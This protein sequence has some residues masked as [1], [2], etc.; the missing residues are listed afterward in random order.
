MNSPPGLA[1]PLGVLNLHR[2]PIPF[3][4]SKGSPSE[5][6]QTFFVSVC[7]SQWSAPGQLTGAPGP[8][9]R[10]V[11]SLWPLAGRC[12]VELSTGDFCFPP[13]LLSSWEGDT[14]CPP[15]IPTV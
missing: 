5:P 6:D 15:C 14:A 12:P 2:E 7:P 1:F 3:P 4:T 9:C 13:A 8:G 10:P 11:S